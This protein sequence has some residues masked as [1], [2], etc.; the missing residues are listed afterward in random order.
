MNDG[1]NTYP[2]ALVSQFRDEVLVNYHRNPASIQPW[3]DL[4]EK[5]KMI[6]RRDFAKHVFHKTKPPVPMH[7]R[8]FI[9]QQIDQLLKR[10]REITRPGEI[11]K[12]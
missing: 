8:D 4:D 10:L 9:L 7:E 12:S 2:D 5:A 1:M 6:W 3:D 11:T